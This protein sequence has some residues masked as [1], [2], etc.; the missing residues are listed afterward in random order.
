MNYELLYTG[1]SATGLNLTYREFSPEG[2]ARV[3]FFQNL[4][5]EA[6]AKSIAFEIVNKVNRGG[7]CRRFVRISHPI[8][9]VKHQPALTQAATWRI[10]ARSYVL[11]RRQASRC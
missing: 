1:V 6:A 8:P 10:F 9:F 11:M 4:T 2:L 3:A 5:Y 7:G